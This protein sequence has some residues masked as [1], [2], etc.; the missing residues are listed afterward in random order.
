MGPCVQDRAAEEKLRVG[1]A[2]RA[3]RPTPERLSLL[4][5]RWHEC[6]K[7]LP[8]RLI[9]D[10]ASTNVMCMKTTIDIPEDLLKELMNRTSASTKREAVIMA[11]VEYNQRRRMGELTSVLGTF[12][13]FMDR[14]EL[15]AT[16]EAQ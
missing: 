11:I 12:T 6:V 2:L 4:F 1:P 16:R 13:D 10:S 7:S 5:E 3:D 9:K 8:K 14:T 15:D